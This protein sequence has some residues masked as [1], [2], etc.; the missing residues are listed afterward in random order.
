VAGASSSALRYQTR[1]RVQ[2]FLARIDITLKLRLINLIY[3]SLTATTMA[4]ILGTNI[5]SIDALPPQLLTRVFEF[6]SC[7]RS[8]VNIANS[9]LVSKQFHALSSPFLITTVVIADLYDTLQKLSEVL[10]HP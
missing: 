9:R 4:D 1:L 6:F 3:K 8:H 10:D 2:R 7:D 5:F